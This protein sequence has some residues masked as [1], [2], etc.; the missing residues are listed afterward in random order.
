MS[1]KKEYI[2]RVKHDLKTI[3][4]NLIKMNAWEIEI[5]V[6][7]E[8]INAYRNGG[9]ALGV[10]SSSTITIDDIVDRDETRLNTLKSNIEH[11]KYKLKEYEAYLECLND[12]EYAVI[13]NKYLKNVNKSN[14]DEQIAEKLNCSHT[15]IR[16]WRNSAILKIANC[17]SSSH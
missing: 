8:K 17:Q 10:Q 6:L 2:E 1:I 12:N 3:R 11:T 15:T 13:N 4:N 14:S 16:R 7:E 9:L 5:G